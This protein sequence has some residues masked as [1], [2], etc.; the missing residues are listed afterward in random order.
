M[1]RFLEAEVKA[2]VRAL[3]EGTTLTHLA[4]GTETGVG[5]ST[6][7]T[8]AV[9]EGWSRPRGARAS[10]RIPAQKRAAAA[11][12]RRL[13]ARDGDIAALMGCHR[14]SIAR[15]A[16]PDAPADDALGG[17]ATVPPHLAALHEALAKPDMHKDD[18]APLLVRA[19][20]VLAA[21]AL[22][23]PDAHAA[24]TAQA[25][26]RLAEHVAALPEHGAYAGVRDPGDPYAGPQSFEET[27]ALLEEF[28]L[29]LDAW[30]AER[31]AKERGGAGGAGPGAGEPVRSDQDL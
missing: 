4:I 3:Y 9:K 16:A 25:L 14:R 27:N 20:A 30:N 6:V 2:R 10:P 21:E 28:A 29:R 11:R 31:E 12:L 24:K 8:L 1:P 19:A 15:I 22:V 5:A 26:G 7:S 13:G 18:A 23:R 17:E